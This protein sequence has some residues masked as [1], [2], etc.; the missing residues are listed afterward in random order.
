[1]FGIQ[2]VTSDVVSKVFSQQQYNTQPD[3]PIESR[4]NSFDLK[5]ELVR[6]LYKK[7]HPY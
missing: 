3:I 2:L 1:M 6:E 7:L 5:L 4:P